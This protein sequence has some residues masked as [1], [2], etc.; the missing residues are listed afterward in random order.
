MTSD[1]QSFP[2][3]TDPWPG[4]RRNTRGTPWS[5]RAPDA[6]ERLA[7]RVLSDY[8]EAQRAVDYLYDQQFPVE[9]VAI[10]GVDLMQV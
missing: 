8:A 6:A 10:V 1:D 2:T 5:C 4:E 9:Q 7:D 3:R